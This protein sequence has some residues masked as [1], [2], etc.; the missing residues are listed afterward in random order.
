GNWSVAAPN[1][2]IYLQEV[3]NPN[4]VFDGRANSA[5]NHYYDY[6]LQSSVSLDA[7]V[8]VYLTG[9]NLPRTTDPHPPMIF[10]P[11][12]D[13]S[14]GSGGIVLQDSVYLFPSPFGNLR[15]TTHDGGN[16]ET[17]PNNVAV[18]PLPALVMSDHY[19]SDADG[20]TRRWLDDDTFGPRDH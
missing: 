5:G 1:G 4:G 12:L 18:N 16:L 9:L 6:D 2:N 10:P 11:T 8:G 20:S 15:L 7:G 19:V 3:R 13:I 17:V 14:A